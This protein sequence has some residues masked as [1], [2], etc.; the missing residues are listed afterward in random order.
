MIKLI[1]FFIPFFLG[2]WG[3]LLEG[4]PLLDA[5]FYSINLYLLNYTYHPANLCIELARWL[6][7]LMTAS[8]ILLAIAT[9]RDRLV[10]FILYLTGKSIVV[11][12]SDETK[13]KL[14]REI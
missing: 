5:F 9:L 4:E 6:A 14:L 12:G 1:I 10:H 7:P 2:V 8:G 3:F 13:E 11:Y